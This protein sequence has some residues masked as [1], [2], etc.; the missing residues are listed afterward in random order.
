M[1]RYQRKEGVA[2]K[3][4]QEGEVILFLKGGGADQEGDQD[5]Q[6]SQRSRR[7]KRKKSQ[8]SRAQKN[9]SGKYP[10]N[11]VG[12]LP[13]HQHPP[14][15]LPLG[16]PVIKRK[17]RKAILNAILNQQKLKIER[18]KKGEEKASEREK[19]EKEREEG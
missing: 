11:T 1:S 15:P 19:T 3:Q 7:K 16:H 2:A 6:R 14:H 17:D 10:R 13:L 8:C 18:R 12:H 9:L 5:L 4:H